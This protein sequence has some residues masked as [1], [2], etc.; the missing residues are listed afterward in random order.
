M[1]WVITVFLRDGLG[2][3]VLLDGYGVVGAAFDSE[4]VELSSCSWWGGDK[5][6]RAVVRNDHA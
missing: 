5:C 6:V 3:Q 4:G 1:G 2:A